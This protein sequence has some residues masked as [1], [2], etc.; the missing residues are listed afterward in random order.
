MNT[1]TLSVELWESGWCWIINNQHGA[2]A[3]ESGYESQAA[4]EAVGKQ[5]LHFYKSL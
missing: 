5:K 3:L 4:A 2:I 1:Y